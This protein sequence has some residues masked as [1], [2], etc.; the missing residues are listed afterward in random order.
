MALLQHI[1]ILSDLCSALGMRDVVICTGSRSAALT[2][3]FNRN[4]QI[5]TQVLADE[6][7]A[8]F[9][10]LG[11]S[12]ISK[13]P[14]G[15]V[16]TSGSAAF[17][18]APAVSEAFFQ[19]IPLV[20]F[21]ADRPPE[22]IHQYDGQTIFQDAIFGKHVK[23]SY[24]L[25][26]DYTHPDAAWALQ[27]I[28]NEAYALATAEP[29]GPVHINV[30]I[31]EPFYPEKEETYAFGQ[32]KFKKILTPKVAKTLDTDTWTTI[33][34]LWKSAQKPMIAI[35]QQMDMNLSN[36]LK[37]LPDKSLIVADAISNIHIS[38]AL[39]MQDL[40]CSQLTEN[41]PD[42]LITCGK[43][44][45]S[46][47]FKKYIRASHGKVHIHVQDQPDIIDPLQTM[48]HKLMV[49]PGYFFKKL[50]AIPIDSPSNSTFL[51]AW[52]SLNEKAKI[53][54]DKILETA[55][56]SQLL[57]IQQSLMLATY[58][59]V[60]IGNSMPVRY[61]NYLQ[62]YIKPN[63]QILANRGTSGIDGIVSTAIG[64]AMQSQQETLCIVGDVSFFYDSNAL[65]IYPFPKNLSIVVI[66]N[67]GGNIFR[68]IDGPANTPE[69]ETHFVGRQT[70][71]AQSL[72]Q[73]ACISYFKVTE[74]ISLQKNL[75]AKG[76]K[77][78][79]VFVDA[80]TDVS[81]LKKLVADF[82]Q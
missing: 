6:R 5:N 38:E 46:K 23:K 7:S 75:R 37:L 19:E 31:R 44:F 26:T 66:N 1:F 50:A 54:I 2:L 79:E 69:L 12:S 68:Q 58:D 28:V 42:L 80:D 43:S 55:P 40:I 10:A 53:H 45:I 36:F 47:A 74:V 61:L 64:Q 29:Q 35:G 9:L 3:A 48:S 25:P 67:A 62:A 22:W 18:F 24:T 82:K 78:I 52:K 33:E 51:N 13:I 72:C 76:P 14:T 20:V 8:G 27:R 57:A 59:M 21:T 71:N 73:E 70:R 81:L 65:F 11:K 34:H 63:T 16:C 15:L 49:D 41:E 30:P 77:V 56:W 4:P 39:N 60:H 32:N 17:N